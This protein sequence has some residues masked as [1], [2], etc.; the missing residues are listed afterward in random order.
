MVDSEYGEEV[1]GKCFPSFVFF[2][3][4]GVP[5][6]VGGEAK[7]QLPINPKQVVWGVKRLVGLSYDK[8]RQRGE[9]QRFQYDIEEGP[10]N[11]ILIRV[12]EERFAPSQILEIILRKIKNDA[13]NT[14]LNP[15]L[16]GRVE[17]AVISVPAYF[18]G[19]RVG[20]IKDAASHAGFSDVETIAEPTAAALMYGLTLVGECKVLTFDIGAGTLDVT[21]MLFVGQG[22]S[23][24]ACTSGDEAL[25]GIDMDDK[26][27]SYLIKK[28]NL[29]AIVSDPREK[30]KLH[31]E[32]EKAKIRLSEPDA[33]TTPLT[34]PNRKTH[35]LT[36]KEL[37]KELK[38]VIDRCRGPVRVALRQAGWKASELDHVIFVGG[39]TYM[40]CVRAAVMDELRKLGARRELLQELEGWQEDRLP[41]DPMKCVAQGAA[42]KAGEVAKPTGVTDPYGYGTVIGPVP[43]FS[44]YFYS[45]ISPGS[46]YPISNTEAISHPNPEALRVPISLIKKQ[47][48][49]A[50][51]HNAYRYYDLG[52]YDCYIRSTGASPTIDITME[53]NDQ[54]VLITTLTHRQTKTAV[55]FEK[56]DELRGTEIKLQELKP[57]PA[58]PGPGPGGGTPG[59][60]SSG[61]RKREWS[62]NQ[63]EK[64]THVARTVS[65][66]A[67]SSKDRK[68]QEKRKKLVDVMNKASDAKRDTPVI[69]NTMQELL[70]ALKNA[71]D[72]PEGDF[73]SYL[74]D[75][76]G[77]AQ[78]A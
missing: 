60:T 69:M 61:G 52:S 23:G 2:D 32:V 14:R 66:F 77:I 12:G 34:L 37:E 48:Y 26:L 75:L 5:K 29:S 46:N 7:R 22:I 41:V 78:S 53:L 63:L 27:M 18:D 68:V 3:Q 36:R 42:L 73:K 38:E 70:N 44:D 30:A 43:G 39:P 58:T 55:V 20:L 50:G 24:E 15:L 54:R 57:P 71:G 40:P 28:H 51:G 1:Y 31:D 62:R 59:T 67:E 76:Q 19:T 64:A 13:E 4:M 35:N 56:L 8:A 10:R 72:L 17:K 9:L 21:L 6:S 74:E 47:A 25:G 65:D 33:E 11:S 16:E 49:D 45:I